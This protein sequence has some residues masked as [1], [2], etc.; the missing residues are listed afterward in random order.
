[1]LSFLSLLVLPA[2]YASH[3]VNPHHHSGR[4]ID[5]HT[6]DNE[7]TFYDAG[8][9]ACGGINRNSDFVVAMNIPQW[10]GGAD[11]YKEITITYKGKTAKAQVVDR[12]GHC[13]YGGLDLSRGLFDFFEDETVGV[14]HGDWSYV[15]STP[16]QTTTTTGQQTNSNT[17][18][19]STSKTTS[20]ATT[21]KSVPPE[22]G[23]SVPPETSNSVSPETRN[24]VPSETSHSVSQVTTSFAA[25]PTVFEDAPSQVM[26]QFSDALVNLLGLVVQAATI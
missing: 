19:T 23:N 12:C 25:A 7:F 6:G 5:A 15:D 18:K 1:M 4:A 10:D 26:A 13:A 16:Q 8:L 11:C 24:L 17:S 2:A 20:L 9:G 22:T 21:S 3:F 14:I